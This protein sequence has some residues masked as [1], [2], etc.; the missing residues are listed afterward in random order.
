MSDPDEAR[1]VGRWK[2]GLARCVAWRSHERTA[3][4]PAE[5]AESAGHA[6]GNHSSGPTMNRPGGGE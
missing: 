5:R 4:C 2:H 6:A 3:D 1:P